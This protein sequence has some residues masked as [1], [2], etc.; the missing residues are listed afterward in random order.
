VSKRA[1]E[2]Y[3]VYCEGSYLDGVVN[4][5]ERN[6][7]DNKRLELGLTTEQADKIERQCAPENVVEYS[8]FVE[9]VLIDGIITEDERAFLQKK[10]KELNL[11]SWVAEQIEQTIIEI[12]KGTSGDL[13]KKE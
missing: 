4:I 8:R 2:E 6:L 12:G 11:D 9:G 3:R 7:L 13:Q 10:I 5:R 1:Q